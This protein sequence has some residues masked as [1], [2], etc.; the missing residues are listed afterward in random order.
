MGEK[1]IVNSFFFVT[2]VVLLFFSFLLGS[3]DLGAKKHVSAGGWWVHCHR[4][5]RGKTCSSDLRIALFFFSRAAAACRAACNLVL[6]P[7]KQFH[8]SMWRTLLNGVAA[9]FKGGSC[10]QKLHDICAES[11]KR[12][13]ACGRLERI[14][15]PSVNLI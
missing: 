13:T 5:L 7:A 8:G 15:L 12:L 1:I 10:W 14:R 3:L 2:S 4:S 9:E 11:A 6:L